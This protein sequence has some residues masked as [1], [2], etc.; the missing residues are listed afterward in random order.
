[1]AVR[2]DGEQVKGQTELPPEEI[3]DDNLKKMR[4]DHEPY[5]AR[6]TDPRNDTAISPG[7]VTAIHED[8]QV[9]PKKW[10]VKDRMLARRARTESEIRE[11]RDDVPELVSRVS[12]AG[13]TSS[14]VSYSS[15]NSGK[16]ALSRFSR[17]DSDRWSDRFFESSDGE[18]DDDEDTLTEELRKARHRG[19]MGK[20]D[21]GMSTSAMIANTLTS[22]P[23]STHMSRAKE[24]AEDQPGEDATIIAGPEMPLTAEPA[25]LE[26]L[27]H[28]SG[29]NTPRPLSNDDLPRGSLSPVN[30]GAALG[31]SLGETA[32]ERR[33]RDM[34]NT[35]SKARRG[36]AGVAEQVALA[37]RKEKLDERE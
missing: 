31:L 6:T 33:R 5:R 3:E 29:M 36:S 16:A 26:P 28:S 34:A 18:D 9:T 1:M 14:G 24:E 7:S 27:S 20:S 17:P 19:E 4:G 15:M 30:T 11:S 22:S 10:S 2:A 35:S 21:N 13:E 8:L 37:Q 23:Q 12:A 25:E 32:E